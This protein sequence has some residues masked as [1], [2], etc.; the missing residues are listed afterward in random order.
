MLVDADPRPPP[1]RVSDQFMD[2]RLYLPSTAAKPYASL[3]KELYG[4]AGSILQAKVSK[5]TKNSRHATTRNKSEAFRTAQPHT[6]PGQQS[7]YG[8]LVRQDSGF[9]DSLSP[10]Q[11][12]NLHRSAEKEKAKILKEFSNKIRNPITVAAREGK[13]KTVQPETDEED[14]KQDQGERATQAANILKKGMRVSRRTK[15]DPV[16]KVLKANQRD[17]DFKKH[18][19]EKLLR[20]LER[21]ELDKPILMQDKLDMIWDKPEKPAHGQ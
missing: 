3:K 21:Y 14:V 4:P 17:Y 6:G 10:K 12:I 5:T 2:T 8:M 11:K 13:S 9:G 7:Q 19:N 20:I 16:Y 15:A 1:D 18:M